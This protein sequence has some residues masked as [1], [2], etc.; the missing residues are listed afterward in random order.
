MGAGVSELLWGPLLLPRRAGGVAGGLSGGPGSRL[1]CRCAGS[2]A[3]P[4]ALAC[5]ARQEHCVGE[6]SWVRAE[7]QSRPELLIDLCCLLVSS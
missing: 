1:G 3:Q 4:S 2:A 6:G 5:A 7:H